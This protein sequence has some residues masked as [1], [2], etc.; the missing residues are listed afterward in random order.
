MIKNLFKKAD[1]FQLIRKGNVKKVDEKLNEDVIY[2]RSEDGYFPIEIALLSNQLEIVKLFVSRGVEIPDKIDDIGIIHKLVQENC[3][4]YEL[5]KYIVEV[6]GNVNYLSSGVSALGECMKCRQTDFKMVKTLLELGADV[7]ASSD[8][9]LTPLVLLIKNYDKSTTE[10]IKMLKLFENSN[11]E[12]KTKRNP[13]FFGNNRTNLYLPVLQNREHKLFIQLLRNLKNITDE[14]MDTIKNY[15]NQSNFTGKIL[16]ELLVTNEELSLNLYFPASI[17]QYSE[18]V[19]Q[20]ETRDIET[21]QN[22]NFV[23]EFCINEKL[24]LEEKKDLIQKFISKGG[25]LKGIKKFGRDDTYGFNLLSYIACFTQGKHFLELVEYLIEEGA[26]IECDGESALFNALWF[27]KKDYAEL[28]LRKGANINFVCEN[29]DRVFSRIGMVTIQGNESG[30][31]ECFDLMKLVYSHIDDSKERI[32]LMQR[33]YQYRS[34]DENDYVKTNPFCFFVFTY[35]SQIEMKVLDYYFENGFDMNTTTHYEEL[36]FNMLRHI[37]NSRN[38]EFLMNVLK[39]HTEID[40]CEDDGYPYVLNYLKT[41]NYELIELLIRRLSDINRIFTVN[42]NNTTLFEQSIV[43]STSN[44]E[45]SRII[46][47]CRED[48]DVDYSLK[49]STIVNAFKA[50]YTIETME[51]IIKNAK[52]VDKRFEYQMYSNCKKSHFTP[53][54]FVCS[55]QP[56]YDDARELSVDQ[57]YEYVINVAKMLIDEGAD[58]NAKFKSERI[59]R[60]YAVGVEKEEDSILERAFVSDEIYSGTKISELLL[61]SGADIKVT[62]GAFNTRIEHFLTLWDHFDDDTCISHFELLKKYRSEDLDLNVKT[63]LG[64]NTVLSAAQHCRAKLIQWLIEN[65]ADQF[66]IGGHDNSNAIDRAI[67]VWPDKEPQAR[68]ETVKVLLEAGLDI[69]IRNPQSQTPLMAAAEVGALDV[70]KFLLENGADV[71][72]VSDEGENAICFAVKGAYDYQ[73]TR[74]SGMNESN[75]IRIINLLVEYGCDINCVPLEGLTP[76]G[77]SIWGKYNEIFNCLMKLGADINLKDSFGIT[78]LMRTI[79]CENVNAKRS[80]LSNDNIDVSIEDKNGQNILFYLVREADTD[81]NVNE[82]IKFIN[83][84]K[85]PY[86]KNDFGEYPLFYAAEGRINFTRAILQ[87]DADLNCEDVKG[88]TPLLIACG[89]Y[90]EYA[91]DFRFGIQEIIIEALIKKGADINYNNKNGISALDIAKRINNSSLVDYLLSLGAKPK[92]I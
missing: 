7:N 23:L 84:Y 9:W 1:I 90:I 12:F 50:K 20:I 32:D 83:E 25:E 57:T 26:E 74:K 5:I 48:L 30:F 11:V 49:V 51:K 69:E 29:G 44:E 53:L 45:V 87:I 61:S 21:M 88:A 19:K 8:H 36:D 79:L 85:A 39:T 18:L 78:P 13:F 2:E 42:G 71:E 10:K 65:G 63:N 31:D 28:F 34:S 89:F 33:P 64:N 17:Y 92:Q 56:F 4:N 67:T 58:V 81:D 77:Y 91:D 76:L 40:T 66:M 54:T 72:A 75:K 60:K 35:I 59:E 80:L 70:V 86:T 27:A 68:V 52:D 6:N 47:D 55:A 22:E 37:F 46:L 82:F 38:Q 16:D 62:T 43:H 24:L 41:E 3:S 73:F 15:I 14:E